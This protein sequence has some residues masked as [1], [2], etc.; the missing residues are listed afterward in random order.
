MLLIFMDLDQT[1]L[2]SGKDS[3]LSSYQRASCRMITGW[4]GG[5]CEAPSYSVGQIIH[6]LMHQKLIRFTVNNNENCKII[7]VTM[8][9]YSKETIDNVL[10]QFMNYARNIACHLNLPVTLSGE[11]GFDVINRTMLDSYRGTGDFYRE[12][13]VPIFNSEE[14]DLFPRGSFDHGVLKKIGIEHY[15][16]EQK[17]P[18]KS[19]IIVIDDDAYVRKYLMNINRTYVNSVQVFDPMAEHYEMELSYVGTQVYYYGRKAL[20][21]K[22]ANTSSLIAPGE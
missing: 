16:D 1:L 4:G 3:A 2:F 12:A 14:I 8:G 21:Q 20:E 10:I 17:L 7:F 11:K 18:S 6:W 9:R 19:D 5:E 15:L 13:N 22:H